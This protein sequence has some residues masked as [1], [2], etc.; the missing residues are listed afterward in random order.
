MVLYYRNYPFCCGN[1][2]GRHSLPGNLVVE[3]YSGTKN[4]FL[5][6]LLF[7]RWPMVFPSIDHDNSVPDACVGG[8]FRVCQRSPTA[9]THLSLYT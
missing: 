5:E 1:I 7:G 6:I 8:L 4:F 3:Y 9:A 2:F